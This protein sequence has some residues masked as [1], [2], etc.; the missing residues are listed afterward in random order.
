M[1]II[2][3]A[4]VVFSALLCG[5]VS[6]FVFLPIAVFLDPVAHE[7]DIPTFIVG[8][9]AAIVHAGDPERLGAYFA[10]AWTALMIVCALPLTICALVGEIARVRSWLWY[11]AGTGSVAAAMPLL[12]RAGAGLRTQATR[13]IDT[14]TQRAEYRFLLLFFLTGVLSGTVYWLIA[15]RRASKPANSSEAS[16]SKFPWSPR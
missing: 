16:S 1:S 10:F 9:L 14:A 5:S 11:A 15:G 8:L 6:A 2:G 4:L 3:R 13:S 12:L 7:F